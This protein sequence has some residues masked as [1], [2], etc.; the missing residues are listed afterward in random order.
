MYRFIQ[1]K[2]LVLNFLAEVWCVIISGDGDGGGGGGGGGDGED[3]GAS[4]GGGVEGGG[5]SMD[6]SP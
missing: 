3:G 2:W 6:I 1:L 4:Y 5:H